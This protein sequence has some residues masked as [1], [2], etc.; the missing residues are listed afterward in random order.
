MPAGEVCL[1]RNS[2]KLGGFV[3]V[4][5]GSTEGTQLRGCK[6][7]IPAPCW[8]QPG[9]EQIRGRSLMGLLMR[10]RLSVSAALVGFL[11]G[12]SRP[13]LGS[14]SIFLP[15]SV[16]PDHALLPISCCSQQGLCKPI[17]ICPALSE[18]SSCLPESQ[19]VK[20]SED[21]GEKPSNPRASWRNSQLCPAADTQNECHN[22]VVVVLM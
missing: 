6:Q 12:S 10:K 19:A 3:C 7:T 1:K 15:V 16:F 18:G 4:G 2:Q 11:F 22:L 8:L 20:S 21:K 13:M 17:S 9:L 5:Q 14:G